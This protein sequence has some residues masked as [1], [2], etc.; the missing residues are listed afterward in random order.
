MRNKWNVNPYRKFLETDDLEGAVLELINSIE[1]N[2]P[3]KI[4]Y[5][6]PH[7][8]ASWYVDKTAFLEELIHNLIYFRVA[9]EDYCRDDED[10]DNPSLFEGTDDED[11]NT[12]DPE[13]R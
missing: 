2:L 11:P 8:C 6:A 3:K 13:S 10:T 5:V 9:F 1:G 12:Y 7:W 4:S